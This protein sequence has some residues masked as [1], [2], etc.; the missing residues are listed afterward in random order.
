[1]H[2]LIV[3][4]GGAGLSEDTEW[5]KDFTL[6]RRCCNRFDCDVHRPFLLPCLDG[7]CKL[8]TL[9][10]HAAGKTSY[11]CVKC[12]VEHQVI[13]ENKISLQIDPLREVLSE[14]YSLKNGDCSIICEMCTNHQTA[15]HRCVDC[16]YFICTDCV[17]LHKTLKQFTSH[18]ILGIENLL[19]GK[20]QDLRLLFSAKTKKCPVS[21]HEKENIK[22]FCSSPSCMKSICILCA[23]STHKEHR[24]VDI[25][26]ACKERESEIQNRIQ[27]ILKKADHAQISLTR[28]K[29]LDEKYL[30]KSQEVETEIKL[31]FSEAK[32]ALENK[33]KKFL[34][35]LSVQISNQQALIEN[36]KKRLTSFV[37][38]CNQACNYGRW[39]SEFN[40]VES[41]LDVAESIHSR[42]KTLE[43][44][45]HDSQVSTE[46][47]KFVPEPS[48]AST[49]KN[50]GKLSV[51]KAISSKSNVSVTPIHM[52]EVQQK[53]QF[54]IKLFSS[55]GTPIVDED[56]YVCLQLDGKTFKYLQCFIDHASSS[57]IGC[58]IPD[59]PVKLTWIVLTNGIKMETL[60]GD[61][62]IRYPAAQTKSK[63]SSF[64]SYYICWIIFLSKLY[65]KFVFCR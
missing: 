10:L 39:C 50:L 9:D 65:K 57:F 30:Q 4:Q 11:E 13:K 62:H 48:V 14:I 7:L 59:K 24:V 2:C 38:S 47:I 61:L 28:L 26:N 58:W 1:M 49:V 63:I 45:C 17:N 5:L 52:Y 18:E 51:S 64:S 41:F 54:Q 6:C 27:K 3:E 33:E 21:G 8:C 36:E 25:S 16:S 32:T 29:D 35:V 37:R 56:V 19:T 43:Y 20:I 42:F 53:V 15:S 12:L 22:V 60:K 44:Q 31:Y 55:L 34:D 40:N 23:I 46:T